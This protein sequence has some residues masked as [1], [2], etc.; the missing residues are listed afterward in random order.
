M[1]AAGADG[2]LDGALAWRQGGDG[3]TDALNM[4]CF[5]EWAD[6]MMKEGK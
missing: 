2:L 3:H 4:K 6:R 1:C 5:V